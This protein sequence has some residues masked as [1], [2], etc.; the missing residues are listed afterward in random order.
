MR[1]DRR[2]VE[3]AAALLDSGG[4]GA[5]TL[6]AVAQAVG[7]SHNAPYKHFES[8]AALLAAVAMGDFERL[9]EAFA[10]IRRAEGEPLQKLRRALAAFVSY[11]EAYPARYRLLFNDPAIGADRR[12]MEA[13]ATRSFAEFAAIVREC[14]DAQALPGVP[15]A[16]LTG[17]IYASAHGLINLQAGGRFRKEKGLARVHEGVDLLV[18]LLSRR[19]APS[20]TE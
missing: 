18:G 1:T 12:D 5:V 13:A 11:A 4:E 19:L 10:E 8:R 14:Q 20:A 16:E 6:R 7:M 9:A 3:A 2:I 17:L 15:N